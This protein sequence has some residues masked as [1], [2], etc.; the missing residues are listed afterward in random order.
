MPRSQRQQ[1]FPHDEINIVH[2]INRCVRRSF[3][4]GK[5]PVSGTDFEYR[6]QWIR[7]RFQFL[8]GIKGIEVL[9]FAVISNHFYIILRETPSVP[10]NCRRALTP[11]SAALS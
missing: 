7:N 4:C 1:V 9:G 3:L 5:D 8:A 10:P 2:C 6:R 11:R